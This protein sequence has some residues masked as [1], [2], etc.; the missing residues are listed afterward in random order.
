MSVPSFLKDHFHKCLLMRL[1]KAL[2]WKLG[3]VMAKLGAAERMILLN[4][5]E[6][7]VWTTTVR[8]LTEIR[9]F[10]RNKVMFP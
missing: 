7:E 5:S 6:H 3:M 10:K 1:F 9:E 2:P 4:R 8:T